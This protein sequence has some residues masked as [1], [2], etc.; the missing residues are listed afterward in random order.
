MKTNVKTAL[1]AG[2]LLI[3]ASVISPPVFALE[4]NRPEAE[5]AGSAAE[6]Q[7]YTGS[8]AQVDSLAQIR[9]IGTTLA[10]QGGQRAVYADGRYSIIH[11]IDPAAASRL[12]ADILVLSNNAGVDH[13][14]NLRHIISAYLAAEYGYSYGD[15]MTLAVFITVYNAV[16]RSQLEY[17]AQVYK[18]SVTQFL[19]AER[20][21]LSA[22]YIDW[23]GKTQI[24]IPLFDPE[25][26]GLSTVDTSVISDEQVVQSMRENE[27]DM[28]I[29]ARE[30]LA[31]LK[32]READQAEERAG[33]ATAAASVA[34]ERVAQEER[35]LR[36]EQKQLTETLA[37]AAEAAN[38]GSTDADRRQAAAESQAAAAQEQNRAVEKAREDLAHERGEAE[39]QKK[40][41]ETKRED[42]A[43]SRAGIEKDKEQMIVYVL[44][45]VDASALFS[46]LVRVNGLNGEVLGESALKTIRSRVMFPVSGAF[47]AIA[48]E[49]TQ[50]SPAKLVLIDSG[51]MEITGES[52]ETLAGNA[53]LVTDGAS[54]Y[55]VI[56]GGGGWVLAK[57]SAGLDMLAS[58]AVRVAPETALTLTRAGIGAAGADGRI[59]LFGFEDLTEIR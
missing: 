12:D 13:I 51:T 47:L 37:A 41:A 33:A 34:E 32:G 9:A 5:R 31:D 38:N 10:G 1:C 29:P 17:F 21:G 50:A 59:K 27:G 6:F 24:V 42:A 35:R 19:I 23:P 58:S 26:G 46:K 3:A 16:Y 40:L 25:N 57:Y 22:S 20:A 39:A 44:Q 54:Y 8:H 14:R 49:G 18:S 11:A 52:D 36:E 56:G 2:L 30:S 4:V 28:G 48:G 43:G 7:N 15:S 45:V 55:T 53:A